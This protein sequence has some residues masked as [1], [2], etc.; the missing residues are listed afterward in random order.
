MVASV[1]RRMNCTAFTC[2]CEVEDMRD[3]L[4][5]LRIEGALETLEQGKDHAPLRELAAG[6]QAVGPEHLPPC[7]SDPTRCAELL[8]R[9]QGAIC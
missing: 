4:D 2:E 6:K 9:S 7:R 5:L 1:H 8:T 3:V